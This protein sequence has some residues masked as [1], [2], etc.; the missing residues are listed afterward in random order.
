MSIVE[1]GKILKMYLVG[2]VDDMARRR[3]FMRLQGVE[4]KVASSVTFP[5]LVGC[6]GRGGDLYG[7]PCRSPCVQIVGC[8]GHV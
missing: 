3:W 7:T 2:L 5:R 8:R 4:G 1:W 6:S